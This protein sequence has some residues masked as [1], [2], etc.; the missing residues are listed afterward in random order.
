MGIRLTKVNSQ[1][2]CTPTV[3]RMSRGAGKIIPAAIQKISRAVA[4]LWN[5]DTSGRTA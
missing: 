2:S 3:V 4:T 1:A 5:S